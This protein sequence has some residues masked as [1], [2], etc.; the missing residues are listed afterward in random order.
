MIHRRFYLLVTGESCSGA[1]HSEYSRD[2]IVIHLIKENPNR[3]ASKM[4]YSRDDVQTL[5]PSGTR[6]RPH[7]LEKD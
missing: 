3:T 6:G 5:D 1:R 4:F 7:P 2:S